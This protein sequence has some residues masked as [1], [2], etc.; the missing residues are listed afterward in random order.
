MEAGGGGRGVDG[1][2]I[3]EWLAGEVVDLFDF[4]F[5]GDVEGDAGFDL[6]VGRGDFFAGDGD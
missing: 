6:V 2:G 3:G 4:A 1:G 5:E